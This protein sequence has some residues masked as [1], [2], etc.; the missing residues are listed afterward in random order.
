LAVASLSVGAL[1]RIAR[2]HQLMALGADEVGAAEPAERLAQHGPVLRIVV[3]EEGLV[4]AALLRGF[5]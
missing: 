4:Q 5:R 3:A 2:G 1:N